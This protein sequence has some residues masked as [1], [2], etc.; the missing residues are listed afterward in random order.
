MLFV[1]GENFTLRGQ[2]LIA[3]AG[4]SLPEG[5]L[6]KR[7]CFLWIPRIRARDRDYV[8]GG[9]LRFHVL[10]TRATYY[11]S[12]QG[13]A[14]EVEAVRTSLWSLGFSP[15]VFKKRKGQRAKGVDIA[16]TKDVLSHAFLGNFRIAVLIAGD[17]DYLPLVEE[18]K[19]LGKEVV[20]AFF[21]E[22]GLSNELK[23]AGDQFIDLT[24][25]FVETWKPYCQPRQ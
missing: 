12:V 17:A 9:S 4:L 8:V 3:K 10:A 25:G 15:F 5:P 19:R 1:D 24:R 16:L 7:D 13:D 6:Y 14:Q 20:I 23:L 18:V 11:T 21:A 2:E 22:D